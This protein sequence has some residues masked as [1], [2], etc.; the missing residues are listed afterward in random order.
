MGVLRFDVVLNCWRIDR[1]LNLNNYCEELRL[2]LGEEIP[3]DFSLTND[4]FRAM[5]ELPDY[6]N[7]LF[8]CLFADFRHLN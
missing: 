2:I 7:E 1:L 5:L 4:D 8:F 6:V 3:N